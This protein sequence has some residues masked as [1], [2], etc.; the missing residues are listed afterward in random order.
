[1]II[2]E[3]GTPILLSKY[4][5]IGFNKKGILR[6]EKYSQLAIKHGPCRQNKYRHENCTGV[7]LSNL[8]QYFNVFF[9]KQSSDVTSIYI[10]FVDWALHVI[11]AHESM[12][13]GSTSL[14]AVHKQSPSA[15][16]ATTEFPDFWTN[17]NGLEWTESNAQWSLQW[18][19]SCPV[20]A[21]KAK[22]A[23]PGERRVSISSIKV[24]VL[25]SKSDFYLSSRSLNAIAG[26]NHTIMGKISGRA[27][28]VRNPIC[29][30]G[31]T[32]QP[33]VLAL[34]ITSETS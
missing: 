17:S 32:N 6:K 22:Q 7:F 19:R 25:P 16:K 8:Y 31:S 33:L 14:A 27:W 24:L 21:A 20:Y 3:I 12:S 11:I 2:T 23:K 34:N 18:Q 4:R 15:K 13:M 26:M 28:E 30:V 1:M 5:T 9:H 29:P 10:S